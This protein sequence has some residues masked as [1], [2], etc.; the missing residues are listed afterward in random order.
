MT[1]MYTIGLDV[2][3]THIKAVLVDELLN[4]KS[5]RIEDSPKFIGK[6]KKS[7]FD[8]EKLWEKSL[9]CIEG[10]VKDADAKEVAAI[11]VTSMA[12]AGVPLDEM[13]QALYPI[14]PWNDMRGKKEFN[15]LQRMLGA[16]TIYKKTGLICHP[17]YSISKI[18]WLKEKHEDV[19]KNTKVWL[20]VA[21]YIIY[22]LSGEY[23][24]DESL[25]TRTLLYNIVERQ[26]D[27]ELTRFM[28]NRDILPKVIPLGS[29]AGIIRRNLAEK[30]QMN[31]DVKIV[32]AGHDHLSA[33]VAV[34]INDEN[35][36][37]DSIGTS[38]VFVGVEKT[39]NLS[40]ESFQLGFNHG[41]FIDGKYYW[42][43]SLPAA[44]AS[45]E[46]IKSL[47]SANGDISYD[48][49]TDEEKYK[50]ATSI[51]YYPYLN[52]SGTPHVDCS[53]KGMF[54]GIS[55]DNDI[56]D[57]IK[58]VYEGV[59]YESRWIIESVEKI[60]KKKI[61]KIKAVGGAVKN[62]PWLTT[63]CNVMGKDISCSS[64]SEA[65]AV[66]AAML[67][68]RSVGLTLG[69]EEVNY[70]QCSENIEFV[71]DTEINSLYNKKFMQYKNIYRSMEKIYESGDLENENYEDKRIIKS[72]TR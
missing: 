70:T 13:G 44:G 63:K 56:Y 58:A 66:G 67:A 52:G 17:K 61:T 22:R 50:E 51:Y 9:A 53:K 35:E 69:R 26:W 1:N 33:A 65:A 23:V 38:E 6:D 16:Y 19:Y 30:L 3:T 7:Y 31:S 12:E 64:I 62:N 71:V 8:P 59:S 4:V 20:S 11:G 57:L 36:V 40:Y 15:K 2:G 55:G 54:F 43:T 68:G 27:K 37:L 49:F 72:S 34:G 32:A 60:K 21:D 5:I 28:E 18:M 42:M 29:Q 47:L 48:I 39:P 24:T 10:V 14:I 41:C 45:I 46:W 25:A